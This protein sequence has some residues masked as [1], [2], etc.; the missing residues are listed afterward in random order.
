MTTRKHWLGIFFITILLGFVIIGNLHS[1]TDNRLN[2]TW[3][4]VD[5]PGWVIIKSNGSFE[6]IFDGLLATRGTYITMGNNLT[7]TVTHLY[8]SL[9]DDSLASRWYT[10]SELIESGLDDKELLEIYDQHLDTFS[11]DNFRLVNTCADDGNVTIWAR[12]QE[13]GIIGNITGTWKGN[14]GEVEVTITIS[15]IGWIL[16]A[17]GS[18]FRENGTYVWDSEQNHGRISID[19]ISGQFIGT[20]EFINRN[21]LGITFNGETFIFT[22]Q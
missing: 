16:T 22:R 8:G 17:T 11:V 6:E 2:G 9:W 20:I 5:D 7:M 18:D 15:N 13:G 10:K 21:Y 19:R 4:N 3:I 14:F 1:Q 12:R